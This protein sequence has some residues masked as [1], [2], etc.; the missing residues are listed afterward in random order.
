MAKDEVL[1][2]LENAPEDKDYED[3]YRIHLEAER[4][5]RKIALITC[6]IL[7]VVCVV[8]LVV[9]RNISFLFYAA[10]CILVGIAYIKVDSNRK[11]I[12][13]NRLMMGEKHTVTFSEHFI[14]VE[15]QYDTDEAFG[16]MVDEDA[17]ENED[18][19]VI[20]KTSN[21]MAYENQRG[22]LF[23]D[24]KISNLFLYIPKRDRTEEEIENLQTFAKERCSK[25]Y[26]MLEM[27]HVVDADDEEMLEAVAGSHKDEREQYY[28]FKRKNM[29]A[30]DAE[31]ELPDDVLEEAE[32]AEDCHCGCEDADCDC[33]DC[34]CE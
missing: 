28:G 34:D 12:A 25:G 29:Q 32:L 31:D 21:M 1:F 11:F 18:N 13:T 27:T 19:A 16:E 26:A 8:L 4:K 22:F 14:Y 3:V 9:L 10:G 5:D 23:A 17:E 33:D 15:E 20:L 2:T 24:G 7:A 30:D 6:I